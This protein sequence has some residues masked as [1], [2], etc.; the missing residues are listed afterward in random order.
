MKTDNNKTLIT[1]AV[2]A[3]VLL[4]AFQPASAFNPQP[5]PPDADQLSPVTLPGQDR[6]TAPTLLPVMTGRQP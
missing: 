4:L 5:E 1:S 3:T 6:L 2:T